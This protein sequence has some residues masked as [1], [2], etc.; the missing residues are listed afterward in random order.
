M[1]VTAANW[2]PTCLPVDPLDALLLSLPLL[3]YFLGDVR[4]Q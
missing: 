1:S 4:R 2:S 3:S